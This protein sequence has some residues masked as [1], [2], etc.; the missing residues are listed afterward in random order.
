[1][2]NN[3]LEKTKQ[4]AMSMW[5]RTKEDDE[6]RVAKIMAER[7][8]RDEEYLAREAIMKKG[9]EEGLEMD[10]ARKEEIRRQDELLSGRKIRAKTTDLTV[11]RPEGGGIQ[12]Y[13]YKDPAV[14]TDH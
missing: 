12:I 5:N 13:R 1:M 7:K 11:D 14:R 2:M 3:E 9:N 6:K 10:R 4:E 8:L